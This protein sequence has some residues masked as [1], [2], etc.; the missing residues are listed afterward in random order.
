M[1]RERTKTE[2]IAYRASNED[3]DLIRAAWKRARRS[4]PS[5]FPTLSDFHREVMLYASQRVV[6]GHDPAPQ[7][8]AAV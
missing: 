3:A 8:A 6:A 2:A 7:S 5:R 1:A 4:N